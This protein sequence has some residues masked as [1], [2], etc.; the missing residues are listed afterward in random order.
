ML[1]IMRSISFA[2]LYFF[3]SQ[4]AL[5]KSDV[6]WTKNLT[7][8]SHDSIKLNAQIWEP[9]LSDFPGK[10]PRLSF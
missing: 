6:K 9:S 4:M 5:A 10:D 7:I 8:E 3:S 2:V 1:R